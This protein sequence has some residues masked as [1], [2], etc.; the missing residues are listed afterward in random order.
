MAPSSASVVGLAMLDTLLKSNLA[1]S[2]PRNL[3]WARSPHPSAAAWEFQGRPVACLPTGWPSIAS[4]TAPPL[5]A[6]ASACDSHT[7]PLHLACIVA[8]ACL[9]ARARL[10][11]R[12]KP[13]RVRPSCPCEGVARR[14]RFESKRGLH[15]D[16]SRSIEVEATP[17][18]RQR[19]AECR[20]E[21]VLGGREPLW[22]RGLAIPKITFPQSP[23]R[24]HD[25]GRQRTYS[26]SSP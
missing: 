22:P 9:G 10:Y 8:G 12:P 24:K 15:A 23:Q 1:R 16:S 25:P 14:P 17:L 21:V 2:A 5:A 20:E 13:V 11:S 3:M 19:G 26:R 18:E 6:R 7:S 4:L